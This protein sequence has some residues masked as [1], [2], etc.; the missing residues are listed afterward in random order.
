M[1]A[2]N[3]SEKQTNKEIYKKKKKGKKSISILKRKEKIAKDA[4]KNVCA[5][6]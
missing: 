6:N 1:A 2:T 4:K 5:K 3:F